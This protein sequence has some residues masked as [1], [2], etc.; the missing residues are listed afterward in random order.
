MYRRSTRTSFGVVDLLQQDFVVIKIGNAERIATFYSSTRS[1]TMLD[2]ENV[3]TG[4][5]RTNF[6]VVNCRRH[7]GEIFAG[8]Q[9]RQPSSFK[10]RFEQSCPFL[11]AVDDGF[12]KSP[13]E[14]LNA[15]VAHELTVQNQTLSIAITWSRMSA[16][17]LERR[18]ADRLSI[19]SIQPMAASRWSS[20]NVV[21]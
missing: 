5:I 16:S 7:R 17:R 18:T 11:M 15:G 1:I 20:G 6:R 13:E 4:H 10:E 9:R 19:S 12:G 8:G 14:L 3:F 21:R 2:S